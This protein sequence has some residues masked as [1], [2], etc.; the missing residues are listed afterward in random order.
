MID[1]FWKNNIEYFYRCDEIQSYIIQDKLLKN[2]C[3]EVAKEIWEQKPEFA[4]IHV[5][6]LREASN[7]DALASKLINW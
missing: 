4:V 7:P 6:G 1:L 2:W 3:D 5:Q